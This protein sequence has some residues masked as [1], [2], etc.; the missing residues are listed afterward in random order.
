MKTTT[1]TCLLCL[2]NKELNKEHVPPSSCSNKNTKY[3]KGDYLKYLQDN[4]DF[5]RIPKGKLQQGGIGFHAFCTACNGNLG[6]NYVREYKQW[7]NIWSNVLRYNQNYPC[8]IELR[9]ELN[10]SKIGKQI[11]AMFLAINGE[12][13]ANNNL[14]LV[15]YVRNPES[16]IL[17][18][19][20]KLYMYLTKGP[21]VK[22][23]PIQG[24]FKEQILTLSEIAYPP[25]GYVLTIDQK[26]DFI[27][28]LTPIT[29]LLECIPN[30]NY[31]FSAIIN[32]YST[33]SIFPLDYRSR[34]EVKECLQNA[35]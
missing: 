4:L 15:E 9:K 34:E 35:E 1:G 23:L 22:Y 30:K 7:V 29:N 28:G 14:E 16:V 8:E 5:D 27:E 20:Y 33:Y 21:K 11:L 12:I 17:S 19:K 26:E 2:K 10:L 31:H 24:M 6:A 18:K 25:L 32:K 3:V 13:F